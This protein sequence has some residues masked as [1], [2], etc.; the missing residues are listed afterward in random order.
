MKDQRFE[1]SDLMDKLAENYAKIITDLFSDDA[2]IMGEGAYKLRG[3][4]LSI[5]QKIR[6]LSKKE[7]SHGA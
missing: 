6:D 2:Y 4:D 5:S 7:N 1:N 3:C